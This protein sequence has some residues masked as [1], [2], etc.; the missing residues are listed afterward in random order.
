MLIYLMLT[1]ECN[2][3]CPYCYQPKG[4]R[5]KGKMTK[6]VASKALGLLK[7][8][9][10][11][12]FY[13]G[14]PLLNFD[15]IKEIVTENPHL[16]YKMITNG[17]AVNT[18]IGTFLTKYRDQIKIV[19][20]YTGNNRMLELV[21]LQP[22]VHIVANDLDK[23]FS[24]F[25]FIADKG[26]RSVKLSAPRKIAVSDEWIARY[27]QEVK[28][29]IDYNYDERKGVE[30]M[31]W[32]EIYDAY[33]SGKRNPLFHMKPHFCGTGDRYIFVTPTGDIYPCD[34][35]FGLDKY[36]LGDVYNGYDNTF[37]NKIARE[38]EVLSKHC[39]GCEVEHICT[40]GMCL[41]ENLELTGEIFKPTEYW[42]K[43]NK[44]EVELLQ[45]LKTKT[46]GKCNVECV[47]C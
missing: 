5:T 40:R 13:G 21:N 17:F 34:W 4:L 10:S 15:L 8:E 47:G 37:F 18:E 28:K 36:K 43:L 42:C 29:I 41:A 26:F 31:M 23:L 27:V 12:M 20:S 22:G 2:L 46:G 39:K 35:F 24:D 25:R 11:V 30:F 7:E 45:Y 44:A 14:E 33:T 6:E 1:G 38:P 32:F 9:D 3:N 19:W 16:T